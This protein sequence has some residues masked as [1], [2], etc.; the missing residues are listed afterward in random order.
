MPAATPNHIRAECAGRTLEEVEEMAENA[1]LSW[2]ILRGKPTW[3]PSDYD[4][5]MAL[6]D[7]FRHMN[8]MVKNMTA[9]ECRNA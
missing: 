9:K 6:G 7:R 8:A 1:R 3:T 4:E 2:I 5:D